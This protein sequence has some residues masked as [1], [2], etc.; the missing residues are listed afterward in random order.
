M[1]FLVIIIVRVIEFVIIIIA[2]FLPHVL[3]LKRREFSKTNGK[4]M[5]LVV[6]VLN[7]QIMAVTFLLISGQMTLNSRSTLQIWNRNASFGVTLL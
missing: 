4:P 3:T 1:V 5:G 7:G 6:K 2:N